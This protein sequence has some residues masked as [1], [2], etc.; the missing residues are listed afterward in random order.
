MGRKTFESLGRVLPN[1]KHIVITKN[2]ELK[3][4]NPMVETITD[5][6]K[7]EPYINSREEYFVIG[8]AKIY[9]KLMP[10]AIKMYITRIEREF[11]GDTYF[12]EINA[13]EWE[14]L[15]KEKRDKR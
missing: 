9:K 12:P 1:R 15:T 11:N 6:G 2:T 7:L 8:G 14:I 3:Y 13:N 4:E 5:I 10:Y